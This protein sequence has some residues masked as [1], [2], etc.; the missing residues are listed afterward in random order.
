MTILGIDTTEQ[1]AAAAQFKV[2]LATL[3]LNKIAA[4]T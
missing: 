3:H 4:V 1:T 2:P